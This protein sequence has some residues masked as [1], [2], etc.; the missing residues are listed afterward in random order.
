M[1]FL[2]W[3]NNNSSQMTLRFKNDWVISVAAPSS[4]AF[5]LLAWAVA[6]K[7]LFEDRIV[8]RNARLAEEKGLKLFGRTLK[9]FHSRKTIR[10]TIQSWV[11]PD[12]L[13]EGT[14]YLL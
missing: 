1:T 3:T 7:W 4:A 6:R 12:K 8:D 10:S 2:D 11:Y 9:A 5:S 13:N 14:F